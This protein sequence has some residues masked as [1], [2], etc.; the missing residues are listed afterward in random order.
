[1]RR[2]RESFRFLENHTELAASFDLSG[3]A[4]TPFTLASECRGPRRQRHI[5]L[6]QRL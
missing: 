5:G 1:M 6:L 3:T 2:L 4:L